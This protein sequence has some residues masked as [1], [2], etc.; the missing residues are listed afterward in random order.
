MVG[1]STHLVNLRGYPPYFEVAASIFFCTSLPWFSSWVWVLGSKHRKC[2]LI[3]TLLDY[4]LCTV[5]WS[6]QSHRFLHC[7]LHS[8]TWIALD[9]MNT[10]PLRHIMFCPDTYGAALPSWLCTLRQEAVGAYA[11][12]LMGRPLGKNKEGKEPNQRN[13]WKL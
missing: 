5:H 8:D 12:G 9:L 6:L 10:H 1:F 7:P 3:D 2:L 4:A 13:C 11:K